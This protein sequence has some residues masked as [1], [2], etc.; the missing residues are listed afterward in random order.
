MDLRHLRIIKFFLLAFTFFSNT[1]LWSQTVEELRIK[2]NN[3]SLT[4]TERVDCLNNLSR[5]LNYISSV[6][7]FSYA[8][9]AL[10]LS[11]KS[12]YVNGQAYAYRSLASV[13]SY[14]GAYAETI[15]NLNKAIS[16]FRSSGDSIGV[17]NCY[18]TLGHTYR[19]LQ[20][21]EE[22][23]K[24]HQLS[25]KMI[26]PTL[27][28]D[29]IAVVTHNYS[30]ALLNGGFL[31][32]SCELGK[33][34]IVIADSFKIL[35]LLSSCYK[36]MGN[37]YLKKQKA[38]SAD[39]W[40]SKALAISKQLGENSQKIAT[41]ESMLGKADILHLKGNNQA[42]EKLLFEIIG[43]VKQYKMYSYADGVYERLLQDLLNNDLS[44]KGKKI[45]EDYKILKEQIADYQ[46]Q[47][48]F[49]L[50]T[51]T[52]NFI[53]LEEANKQLNIE[54]ALQKSMIAE[55]RQ[56]RIL[57][58]IFSIILCILLI[59][60]IIYF[61]KIK[62]ANQLLL[63]QEKII[64]LKNKELDELNK[65]KDKF[66]SIVSHDFQAPLGSV[67]SFS[68]LLVNNI[69]AIPNEELK[70]LGEVLNKQVDK[71][72]EFAQNLL[73][74]SKL[75]M[76][77]PGTNPEK[78]D[79]V[80]F[81]DNLYR[82]KE[83]LF[84]DKGITLIKNLESVAAVADKSQLEFILRN[85]IRNA[86]KFTP[87]SGSISI[88]AQQQ[89]AFVKIII[90]DSG[91]GFTASDLEKTKRGEFLVSTPGTNQEQG[92]GLGLVLCRE[93]VHLNNGKLL[94]ENASDGGAEVTLILPSA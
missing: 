54:T 34:A 1:S 16:I 94:I 55:E 36:V 6:E 13:Y 17:A 24:Y 93:F 49:S 5:E 32:Q 81:I 80:Q 10:N 22:E 26:L 76:H 42:E 88:T 60:S 7:S 28:F 31:D 11:L 44:L 66:F 35:P 61:T 45:L 82:F 20:R 84:R 64:L 71:S 85:L 14:L 77:N 68:K 78:I 46:N 30:E 50:I 23:I 59:L 58:S 51:A 72:L 73:T 75:Q 62:K 18:I 74:W 56:N 57:I 3:R 89:G 70:E 19:R 2:L 4:V 69:G 25:Y 29:R 33:K 91:A 39:F 8:T 43:F 90:K 52:E 86:I 48:K 40:F 83:P 53:K 9:E 65:T 37:L 47:Q 92:T 87:I 21:N 15:V 27:R 38:D 12:N 67:S 63:E 79:V 41:V